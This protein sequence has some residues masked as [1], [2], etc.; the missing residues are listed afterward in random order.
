MRMRRRPRKGAGADAM[1]NVAEAVKNPIIDA[2]APLKERAQALAAERARER[3]DLVRGQLEAAGWDIRKA[4]PR[5][6]GFGERRESYARKLAQH[7]FVI[8][9][10][11]HT[12]EPR[13]YR[14]ADGSDHHYE[15]DNHDIRRMDDEKAQH[16]IKSMVEA[17]GLSYDAYVAKLTAKIGPTTAAKLDRDATW[18]YSNLHVTTQAGEDQVWRTQM[19]VNVSVLGKLFNQWPTRQV[20]KQKAAQHDGGTQDL[21]VEQDDDEQE[22]AQGR[23][24]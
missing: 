3:V 2:V 16:F 19:I 8:A 11:S 6:S 4:A 9:I 21:G 1:S 24:R 15:V 23:G 18:S 17:S 7:K 14:N 12:K 22:A 20:G 5:P 10:T 13:Q